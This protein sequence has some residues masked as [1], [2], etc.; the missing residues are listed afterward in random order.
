[1]EGC[2]PNS[3]P[4]ASTKLQLTSSFPFGRTSASRWMENLN[5]LQAA[6]EALLEEYR[7]NLEDIYNIQDTLIQDILP[8][9]TDDLDLTPNACAWAKEWLSDTSTVFRIARRNKF[10]R[11]FCLEAVEKILKWRVEN[12]W[13]IESSSA[14]A[15]SIRCL[16][17][18]IRDPL[19]RPI[20]VID[21][22]PINES[23]D[24][25]KR[26]V[27]RSFEKLRLHLK[28]LYDSSE[29]HQHPPLQ[30]V[31]L[32]DL[33]R[34][35]LQSINVDLFTWM[36]REVIPRFPGMLAGVF[37]LNYTWAHS[38][39]W[40]IFKRLLPGN[41]LARIFF[42]SNDELVEFFTPAALPSEFGGNLPALSTLEDPLNPIVPLQAS[43]VPETSILEARKVWPSQPISASWVSRMSLL[44]PFY[45]YPASVSTGRGPTTFRHGRRR[46]RDLASTLAVLF[47]E[48]W[49][50]NIQ[51]ALLLSITAFLIRLVLRKG[52]LHISLKRLFRFRSA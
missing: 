14:S 19:G 18:D 52:K 12:L 26:S 2:L 41:A 37:F 7:T 1:M 49:G 42:P 22:G 30:Y 25:H 45:G 10:T 23:L 35:S 5:R 8:S 31:V 51:Y 15:L 11:S 43:E 47:W 16:P 3:F 32:L 13:P 6:Q 28:S 34:L 40:N 17:T 46:K 48:K 33:S 24:S 20:L 21:M 38:G 4:A 44:N 29:D 27:I 39:L 36:V 9:V 50:K